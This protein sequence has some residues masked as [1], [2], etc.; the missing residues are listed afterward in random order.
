M[1]KLQAIAE[2]AFDVYF[3]IARKE[4]DYEDAAEGFREAMESG[5][6][7]AGVSVESGW[8]LDVPGDELHG[9]I[10]K[11]VAAAQ[12][13][14]SEELSSVF[15]TLLDGALCDVEDSGQVSDDELEKLRDLIA[16]L[17]G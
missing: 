1:S 9:V 13:K 15:H 3:N 12:S 6:E 4:C 11:L 14:E 2:N 16:V 10:S 7:D 8:V 17:E 5:L